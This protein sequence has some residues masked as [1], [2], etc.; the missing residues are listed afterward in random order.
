MARSP[1]FGST[2]TDDTRPV[3]TRFRFGFASETLNPP[4]NVTRRFIL[5]KAR[6]RAEG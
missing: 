1:G 5:Q 3:R 6:H 2:P 4:V